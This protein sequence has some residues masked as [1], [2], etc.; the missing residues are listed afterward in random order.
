M[1]TM[2]DVFRV[3]T[4][5][6]LDDAC[7]LSVSRVTG[8]RLLD[9]STRLTCTPVRLRT[10]VFAATVKFLLRIDRSGK[11]GARLIHFPSLWLNSRWFPTYRT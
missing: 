2:T 11:V 10:V 3:Q 4:A 9:A 5:I 1:H 8:E 6:L 7:A